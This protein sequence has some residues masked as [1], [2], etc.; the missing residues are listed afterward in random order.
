MEGVQTHMIREK[1][2]HRNHKG[3]TIPRPIMEANNNN[4]N[5]TEASSRM[6]ANNNMGGNSSQNVEL[7]PLTNNAAQAGSKGYPRAVLDQCTAIRSAA[8]AIE[9]QKLPELRSLQQACLNSADPGA[10]SARLDQE[11]AKIMEEYH[12]LVGEIRILKS[13]PKNQE[14]RGPTYAQVQAVDTK[15]KTSMTAYRTLDVGFQKKLKD[16]LARQYRIVRPEAS[17]EEVRRAVDSPDGGQVFSQ[18]L[19]QSDRRGQSQ[20]ALSAVRSRHAEIQKI[21]SQMAEL[22][23]LFNEMNELVVQQEAAVTNIEMKGE[24]VVEHMDKG[25]AEIGTA[26]KSAQ[27]ARKWKWWCLG[28]TILIIVIIV[29]VVLIYKFVISAPA[30]AAPKTKRFVLP[31]TEHRVVSG[32]PWSPPV[33]ERYVVP[34]LEWSTNDKPVVP[35]KGWTPEKRIVVPGKEWTPET[36]QERSFQA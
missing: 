11:S 17:E 10:A 18:A 24:E 1:T 14:Q 15:L 27:K 12:S 30:A 6:E 5:N 35:G 31:A 8:D 13:D 20:S 21:D 2:L 9:M 7:E 23:Q 26:I 28:I 16:Q 3:D 19:M 32:Q 25:N 4:N 22:A 34:G 33:K 36:R 29:I